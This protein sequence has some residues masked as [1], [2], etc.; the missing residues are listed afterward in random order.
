MANRLTDLI[1]SNPEA[2][3]KIKNNSNSQESVLAAIQDFIPDYTDEELVSNINDIQ[4]SKQVIEEGELD[5]DQ[6]EKVAGG[7]GSF[8]D[9][10]IRNLLGG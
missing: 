9:D 1:N 10:W 4:K 6:L 3:E 5:L 7:Q 2:K 8:L